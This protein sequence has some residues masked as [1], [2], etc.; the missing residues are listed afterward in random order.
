MTVGSSGEQPTT[1]ENTRRKQR[2]HG[3][4]EGKSSGVADHRHPPDR[5]HATTPR[6]SVERTIVR[7]DVAFVLDRDADTIAF[8]R[9]ATATTRAWE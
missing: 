8:D 1:G 5:M 4:F 2:A 3:N 7:S 6:P 9:C